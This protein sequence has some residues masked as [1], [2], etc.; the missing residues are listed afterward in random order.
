M[1]LSSDQY[2]ALA[3]AWAILE[4]V[5]LSLDSDP[6]SIFSSSH[7][8]SRVSSCPSTPSYTPYSTPSPAVSASRYLPPPAC[9]FTQGKINQWLY[10]I[11]SKLSVHQIIIHSPDAIVEYPQTGESEDISIAHVFPINFDAFENP[12]SSFQYSQAGFMYMNIL[13]VFH[14][15]QDLKVSHNCTKGTKF[16]LI[17]CMSPAMLFQL[18]H[19][20]CISIDMSFKHVGGKWEEFEIETWDNRDMRSIVVAHAFTTSESAN[21]HLILFTRIFDIA[22]HRDDDRDGDGNESDESDERDDNRDDESDGGCTVTMI[23]K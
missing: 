7:P 3:Q 2:T 16:Q 1:N 8:S 20:K 9:S 10:K 6:E 18:L 11:N 15:K 12:E 4:G 19:A 22:K 13:I 23:R 17:V 5:G 14:T 21:A